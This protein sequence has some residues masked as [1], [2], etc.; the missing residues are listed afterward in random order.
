M[1]VI[2]AMR[3]I[4]VPENPE[5]PQGSN[6][7]AVP[8]GLLCLVPDGYQLPADSYQELVKLDLEKNV[9]KKKK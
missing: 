6:F 2:R 3:G 7:R 4:H 9:N 8:Q 5:N 1:R